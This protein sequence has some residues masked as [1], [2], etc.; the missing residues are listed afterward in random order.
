MAIFVTLKT[1]DAKEAV[2]HLNRDRFRTD[3]EEE[4]DILDGVQERPRPVS[5]EEFKKDIEEHPIVVSPDMEAYLHKIGAEIVAVS[6]AGAILGATIGGVVSGAVSFG[7]ATPVGAGLGGVIGGGIG[8][9]ATSLFQAYRHRKLVSKKKSATNTLEQETSDVDITPESTSDD[10][11]NEQ[12]S[13]GQQY[14][15]LMS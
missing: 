13:H 15:R 4:Y 9:I 10:S 8:F 14:P 3:P 7:L 12:S 5:N 6:S 1:E 2:L 11:Q